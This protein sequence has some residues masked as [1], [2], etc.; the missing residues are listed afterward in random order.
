M[1]FQL[2]TVKYM[3]VKASL[4]KIYAWA[5]FSQEDICR[6]KLLTK[7]YLYKDISRDRRPKLRY[8]ATKTKIYSWASVSHENICRYRHL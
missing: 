7:R 2:L 1:K 4:T 6:G 5:N 3:S 8:M